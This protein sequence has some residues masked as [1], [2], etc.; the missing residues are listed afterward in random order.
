MKVENKLINGKSELREVAK[1]HFSKLYEEGMVVRPKLDRLHFNSISEAS[2]QMLET[3]FMEEKIMHGL[4]FCNGNKDPGPDD[5]SMKFLQVFWDLLKEDIMAIFKDLHTSGKFVKSINTTFITLIP[6][7]IG[8]NEFKEFRPISLVGCIYKLI[9]KVLAR[10]LSK[11]LGEVIGDCQHAFVG[12]RQILDA[13]IAANETVDDLLKNKKEGLVCKL[14]MEK[15]YDYV[16]W[17]FFDY[18]FNRM[19]FGVKLRN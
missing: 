9:V 5:F 1:D 18:M 17:S 7:R 6:K 16:N 8:A 19:D 12:G 11:V 14:D 2:R 15:A 13:V 4:K 10:R 3:A